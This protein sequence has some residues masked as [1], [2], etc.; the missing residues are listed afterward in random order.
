[1]LPYVHHLVHERLADLLV[2]PTD[3]GVRVERELV[4]AELADAARKAVRREVAA[5]MRFSLVRYK[6][7]RQRTTEQRAVEVIERGLAARRTRSA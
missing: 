3:E 1:M 7:V 4:L 6:N 2:G 5:R